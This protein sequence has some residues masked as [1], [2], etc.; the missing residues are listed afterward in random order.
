MKF[1]KSL[2][3]NDLVPKNIFNTGVYTA[4]RSTLDESRVA[5][6][7]SGFSCFVDASRGT[8]VSKQTA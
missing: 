7:L 3:K 6:G 4:R 1:L 5:C 8:A 2:K